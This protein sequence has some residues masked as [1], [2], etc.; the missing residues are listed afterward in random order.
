VEVSVCWSKVDWVHKFLW[1]F[2]E[3]YFLAE[4]VVLVMDNLNLYVILLL[5]EAFLLEVVFNLVSRF[6]F[7]YAFKYGSWFNV[8]EV[9]L[10]VLVV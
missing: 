10:L 6:E 7:Y 8:V 1:L 3:V 2:L 4:R 5:C 9:G